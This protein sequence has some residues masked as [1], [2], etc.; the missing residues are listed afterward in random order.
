MIYFGHE[1]SDDPSASAIPL[2]RFLR[3]ALILASFLHSAFAPLASATTPTPPPLP[4]TAVTIQRF[5]D[6]YPRIDDVRGAYRDEVK[7]LKEKHAPELGRLYGEL[8]APQGPG[9]SPSLEHYRSYLDREDAL[10]RGPA[11]DAV[12][13][14]VVRACGFVSVAEYSA[15]LMSIIFHYPSQPEWLAPYS[16]RLEGLRVP[17]LD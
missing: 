8:A 15:A 14:P 11:S 2:G 1:P 12:L 4:L 17:N 7:R 9:G 6:C 10:V 16:H 5:I 13:L 3:L